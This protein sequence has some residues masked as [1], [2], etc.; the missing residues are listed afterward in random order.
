MTR[1][2]IIAR[3]TDRVQ[4]VTGAAPADLAL[5][6]PRLGQRVGNAVICS[7]DIADIE[8]DLEDEFDLGIGALDEMGIDWSIDS[9]ADAVLL[10]APSKGSA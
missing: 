3:I 2:D 10:A 8:I 6:K 1:A 4:F 7:H 5:D 9:I